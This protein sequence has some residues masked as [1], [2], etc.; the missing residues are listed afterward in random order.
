MRKTIW[1]GPK[2]TKTTD[3]INT[4]LF[5]ICM[6]MAGRSSKISHSK[7]GVPPFLD[8]NCHFVV[9]IQLCQ[10]QLFSV[11]SSSEFCLSIFFFFFLF[12][13]ASC[14]DHVCQSLR[15]RLCQVGLSSSNS[16]IVLSC[17]SAYGLKTGGI[18][19]GWCSIYAS[20]ISIYGIGHE[21]CIGDCG[22]ITCLRV[23]N[24]DCTHGNQEKDSD[25]K[26]LEESH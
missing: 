15:L 11:P 14:V 2:D 4:E 8:S 10:S 3:D 17:A 25:Q 6:R 19:W 16:S 9:S 22:C 12:C 20:Q 21:L 24:F 13:V 5:G 26:K 23:S 18:K 1:C 7:R